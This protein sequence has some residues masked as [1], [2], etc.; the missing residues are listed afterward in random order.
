MTEADLDRI[1]RELDIRLPAPYRN[2]M[3][4]FPLSACAGNAETE[5]WD[6]ADALIEVNREL[7]AGMKFVDP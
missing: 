5:L 7:R 1:E 6:D 4:A 2:F 3:A